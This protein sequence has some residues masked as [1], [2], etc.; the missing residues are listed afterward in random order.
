MRL[1]QVTYLFEPGFSILWK[2]DTRSSFLIG[3]GR[4][5][6]IV[7][8]R[9]TCHKVN[10]RGSVWLPLSCL[11]T[12]FFSRGLSSHSF[13]FFV[14]EYFLSTRCNVI[15]LLFLLKKK[16]GLCPLFL[17]YK[18]GEWNVSH[19]CQCSRLLK[20]QKD[21]LSVPSNS[22]SKAFS[23]YFNSFRPHGPYKCRGLNEVNCEALV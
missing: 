18:V 21:L 23:N 17:V 5:T 16:K 19:F 2:G 3:L 20:W 7:Y 12:L 4:W 14:L 1:C 15:F 11:S 9:A 22:S 10:S 8:V 6:K 13:F